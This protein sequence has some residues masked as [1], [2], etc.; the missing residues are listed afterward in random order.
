MW[1]LPIRI[2]KNPEFP[3]WCGGLR[4]QLL[5]LG[6]APEARVP[7][8]PPTPQWVEGSGVATAA[9]QVQSLSW[10]FP[11][12][13]AVAKKKK[14]SPRIIAFEIGT[15]LSEKSLGFCDITTNYRLRELR[16]PLTKGGELTHSEL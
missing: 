11:Y 14:K 3:L 1:T 4:I 2:T 15:N 9:D 12:A 6:V 13:T 7:P 8:P 5:P 10:E 16:V